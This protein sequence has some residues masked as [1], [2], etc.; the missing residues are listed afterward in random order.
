MTMPGKVT[1]SGQVVQIVGGVYRG[2]GGKVCG[3]PDG[4]NSVRVALDKR[5][6]YDALRPVD[7][8]WVPVEFLKIKGE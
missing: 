8:A 5:S 6:A 3:V 7:Y 4:T 1:D 2:R